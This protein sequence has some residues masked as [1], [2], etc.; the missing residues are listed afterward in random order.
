MSWRASWLRHALSRS[1]LCARRSTRRE[2]LPRGNP[3]ACLFRWLVGLLVLGVG[4]WVLVLVLGVGVGVGVGG[5]V[6]V[7]V[8]VMLVAVDVGYGIGGVLVVVYVGY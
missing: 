3:S 2:N 7:G 5:V 1:V 6:V 8:L 4:C